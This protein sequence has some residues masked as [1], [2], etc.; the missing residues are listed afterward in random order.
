MLECSVLVFQ[1]D[2]FLLVSFEY[3]NLILQMPNDDVFLVGLNI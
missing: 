2:E 3:V 1:F